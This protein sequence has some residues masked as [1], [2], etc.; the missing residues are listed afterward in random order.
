[1]AREKVRGQA[2]WQ[3]RKTYSDVAKITSIA[4][5]SYNT[6]LGSSVEC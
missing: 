4:F 5:D 3:A 6:V 2:F 1:M